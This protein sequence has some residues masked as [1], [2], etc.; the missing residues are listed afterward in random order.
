MKEAEQ[1]L[2]LLSSMDISIPHDF[3]EFSLGHWS[4]CT[5]GRNLVSLGVFWLHEEFP[6]ATFLPLSPS[7]TASL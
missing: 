1:T 5:L 6:E 3:R 2:T 4:G 7:S